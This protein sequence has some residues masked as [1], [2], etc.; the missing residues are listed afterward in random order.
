MHKTEPRWYKK[1]RKEHK[2]LSKKT[3]KLAKFLADTDN[4][5]L[6][7]KDQW[8]LLSVQ[9]SIMASYANVLM[10]RMAEE[11]EWEQESEEEIELASDFKSSELDA[12]IKR[13]TGDWDKECYGRS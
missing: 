9:N 10:A 7:G 13:V 6:V 11:D 12:L 8:V 1:V 5:K 4:M 2:K 3:V